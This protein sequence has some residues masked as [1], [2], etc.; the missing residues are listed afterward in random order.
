MYLLWFGAILTLLPVYHWLLA[1]KVGNIPEE[2]KYSLQR[3]VSCP[4]LL[5]SWARGKTLGNGCYMLEKLFIAF[6]GREGGGREKAGGWGV[7]LHRAV[8][9][10]KAFCG[11]TVQMTGARPAPPPLGARAPTQVA[12]AL[13]QSLHPWK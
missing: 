3:M 13:R 9:G 8:Q 11:M 6:G 7:S 2:G 10:G 4:L 12:L 1:F 5:D